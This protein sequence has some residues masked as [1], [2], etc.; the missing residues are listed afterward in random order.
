MV[1]EDKNNRKNAKLKANKQ[2]N[3]TKQTNKQKS[4]ICS[5]SHFAFYG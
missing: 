1:G 4:R 3:K 5:S 2:T